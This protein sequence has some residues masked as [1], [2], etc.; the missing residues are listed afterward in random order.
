MVRG[1]AWE[2]REAVGD[3][4]RTRAPTQGWR[5][6]VSGPGIYEALYT[7]WDA[8]ACDSPSSPIR[9]RWLAH[10]IAIGPQKLP[11]DDHHDRSKEILGVVDERAVRNLEI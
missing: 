6:S 8:S 1:H 4:S 2:G 7:V 11:A 5:A 3:D 10:M 9:Q